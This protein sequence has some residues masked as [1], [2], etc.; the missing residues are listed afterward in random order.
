LAHYHK[1]YYDL[2][3]GLATKLG[4]KKKLNGSQGNIKIEIIAQMK[5]KG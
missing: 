2:S 1:N 3:F 5:V 4:K